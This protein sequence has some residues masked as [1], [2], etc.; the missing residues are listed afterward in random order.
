MREKKIAEDIAEIVENIDL[1]LNVRSGLKILIWLSET[2]RSLLKSLEWTD[3]EEEH[4]QR[5]ALISLKWE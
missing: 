2:K 1:E 4:G 5:G 3:S